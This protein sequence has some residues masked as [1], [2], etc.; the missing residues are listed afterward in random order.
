MAQTLE[1]RARAG[2]WLGV[3]GA[4]RLDVTGEQFSASLH[5]L[6]GYVVPWRCSACAK[7]WLGDHRITAPARVRA[8]HLRCPYGG[9]FSGYAIASS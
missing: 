7:C 6:E 9:P 4:P 2:F 1:E 8:P 5:V 3:E